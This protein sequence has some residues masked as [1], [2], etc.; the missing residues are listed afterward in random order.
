MRLISMAG[1]I[2]TMSL[3][4]F[5]ILCFP[6][7]FPPRLLLLTGLPYRAQT[8]KIFIVRGMVCN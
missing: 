7:L 4:C 8:E 6:P 3:I 5:K 1:Q 2:K